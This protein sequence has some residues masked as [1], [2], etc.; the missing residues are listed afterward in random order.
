MRIKYNLVI[1]IFVYNCSCQEICSQNYTQK[2]DDAILLNWFV[3]RYNYR[4]IVKTGSHKIFKLP[5][6]LVAQLG[7]FTG[8]SPY[9]NFFSDKKFG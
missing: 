1:H 5:V 2:F 9:S 8:G 7:Y 6:V 3:L 4:S